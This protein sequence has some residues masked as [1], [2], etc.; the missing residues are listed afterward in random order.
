MPSRQVYFL[1]WP[2]LRLAWREHRTSWDKRFRKVVAA[3]NGYDTISVAV[4]IAV[5]L[6]A[7]SDVTL[8]QLPVE[9]DA[10]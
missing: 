3:N 9:Q 10:Q 6:A 8:V 4:P 7:M 1:P 5:V 2:Q